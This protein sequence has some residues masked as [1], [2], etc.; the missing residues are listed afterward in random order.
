MWQAGQV[1]S[2]DPVFFGIE[3]PTYNSTLY[4]WNP[5]EF[6]AWAGPKSFMPIEYLGTKMVDGAPADQNKCVTR[7]ETVS[8][9]LGVAAD[10]WNSWWIQALSNG[11][12][13]L[14]TKREADDVDR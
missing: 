3:F 14:F 7:F 6:G 9:L 10:A 5:V 13:G 1:T 12:E 2:Q 4:E 11:T 8:F